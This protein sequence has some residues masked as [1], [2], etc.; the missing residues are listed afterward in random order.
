MESLSIHTEISG[1]C[2]LVGQKLISM[3]NLKFPIFNQC[4]YIDDVGVLVVYWLCLGALLCQ[5]STLARLE[6]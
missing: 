3:W 6:T 4:R 2:V 1:A 5:L